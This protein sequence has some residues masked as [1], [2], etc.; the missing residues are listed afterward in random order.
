MPSSEPN[1]LLSIIILFIISIGAAYYA[2]KKGRNPMIWFIIGL[3]ISVFALI[4][5]Y[6]LP[7]IERENED[8]FEVK[9][10]QG[11]SNYKPNSS[12]GETMSDK[13]PEE[14][15]LWYYLDSNHAQ[16]GPVSIVALKELWDTGRLNLESYVWS[17]G[18]ENWKKVDE[19]ENLKKALNKPKQLF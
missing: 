11:F 16:F 19:L 17:Q 3:L 2:E 14:D 13:L 15:T 6:L 10:N 7:P 12:L 4:I 9:R 8:E 5:L 1:F 18:M